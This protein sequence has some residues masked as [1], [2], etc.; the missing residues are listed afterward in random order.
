MIQSLLTL[1]LQMCLWLPP[2]CAVEHPIVQ[3]WRDFRYGFHVQL[4]DHNPLGH[5]NLPWPPPPTLMKRFAE[6]QSQR[7]QDIALY[8]YCQLRSMEG[9][10]PNL[11]HYQTVLSQAQNREHMA[12]YDQLHT[13]YLHPLEIVEFRHNLTLAR[14]L[15]AE[16]LVQYQMRRAIGQA[17]YR[18]QRLNA[19]RWRIWM[20]S[21]DYIFALDYEIKT[22]QSQFHGLWRR[23]VS[24][25]LEQQENKERE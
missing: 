1:S 2:N 21:Y 4:K 24:R 5:F 9:P 19:E 7:A 18:S 15:Q 8:R 20:D 13:L 12:D 14:L 3:D 22:A 17:R 10:A 11:E 16:E 6:F 25:P 23:Q